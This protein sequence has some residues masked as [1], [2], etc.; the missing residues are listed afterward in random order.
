MKIRSLIFLFLCGCASVSFTQNN[1]SKELA[2]KIRQVE[3]NLLIGPYEVEDEPGSTIE[4]R[5]AFYKVKGLSIA[6]IDNYQIEWAKGYGWADSAEGRKVTPETIFEPGSISK[7]LNA[8]G[9]LKLVQEGK[10]DLNKDINEQLISWKFPY[11]KKSKGNKITPAHLLSHTGGLSQHGFPGYYY[12]DTFPTLL[13][14]LD[15]K[16]P[17]NTEAVRSLFEPGKKHQYSGG[18]SMISEILLTD[19]TGQAYDRYMEE[20]IFKALAMNNSFFTQPPPVERKKQLA[21]GYD[22]YGNEIKGKYPILLEQAAGGLWTTPADLCKF[23]IEL[24]RSFKGESNKVLTQP[25]VKKMM[26]AVADA[27]RDSV[28]LGVFFP[29]TRSARYFSH[30]AGN[31]GF[32]GVYFGSLEGGRGVVIFTN[33]EEGNILT[34]LAGSV[35]KVYHWEE[36]GISEK[37]KAVP[38][39]DSVI[40]RYEGIYRVDGTIGS[41][42][43]TSEGYRFFTSNK[44]WKMYFT[45]DSSFFN[46]E[47]SSDKVFRKTRQ[48]Y[49]MDRYVKGKKITTSEKITVAKLPPDL[50]KKYCGS[51][52]LDQLLEIEIIGDDLFLTFEQNKWKMRFYSE[53]DFFLDE[54][55]NNIFTFQFKKDKV[56]GFR[57]KGEDPSEAIKIK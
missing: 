18:G 15:G 10:I 41:V 53:K 22:R 27:G 12:S 45:S 34:E 1:T 35:A 26:T 3:S 47:S 42:V 2:E 52:K 43:K 44:Y 14:I 49:Q 24:Q 13:Q 29:K 50:K 39:P 48:G 33:S 56:T 37:R 20:A 8:M 32:R 46:R 36:F 21:T 25:T 31:Q 28:G 54:I 38:V 19:V 55:P 17:A 30:G 4:E 40:A 51:Y 16:K 7:S 9:F 6:V 23:I 57:E 11:D 5:M